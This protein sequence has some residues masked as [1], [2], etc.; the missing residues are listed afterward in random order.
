MNLTEAERKI[1]L[2]ACKRYR[3]SLPTYLQVYQSELL[4]VDA[5]IQKLS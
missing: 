5:I 1:L 2:T 3:N 4:V